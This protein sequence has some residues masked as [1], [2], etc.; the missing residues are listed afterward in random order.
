MKKTKS[1]QKAIKA[2]GGVVKLAEKL[3]ITPQAI[4]QWSTAP[5]SRCME[6]ER[7]TGVTRAELRSDHFGDMV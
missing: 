5:I 1:L 3:D 2:A 4:S 7:I 6:I